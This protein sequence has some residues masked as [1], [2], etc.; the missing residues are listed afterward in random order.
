MRLHEKPKLFAQAI[1][2]TVDELG[3]YPEFV[4][5]DYW[6]SHILQNLSRLDKADLCVWKGGTSLAKA[7]RLV[8][9]FSSDVDFAILTD[10]LSQNQQK[11]LVAKIGHDSTVGLNEVDKPD[12]VKKQQIQEDLPLL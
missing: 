8:N 5:K 11:K 1:E 3:V 10:L 12:T 4:E 2:A 6:I 9:R 7:Y